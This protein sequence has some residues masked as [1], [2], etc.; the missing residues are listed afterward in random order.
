MA[1]STR[2][3]AAS[4]PSDSAS[5]SN[6][7]T[8][9]EISRVGIRVPPFWPE[10]PQLWFNQ[11]EAQFVLSG[12]TAD[13]TKFYYVMS[14]L[15]PKYAVQVQ[16]IF[17]NPPDTDKYETL[18]KELV[19]RLS[20][21]QGQ[22][23]RQLLEQ[24]EIGDRTPSQFLRH[25]RNLAGSTVTDDFLR[26]LWSGRLPAMTRAIVTAQADLSLNKL[27]EIADQ[28]HE[29]SSRNQVASV[30]SDRV[31]DM[32]LPVGKRNGTPLNAAISDGPR[33]SRLYVTDRVT[34]EEFLVD[35]GSDICVYP[36]TRIKGRISKTTHELLA[37]NSSTISTHG[38]KTFHLNLGL[39]R[40]F[41]WKFVIA[42]V[43]KP[44]IGA[45]FL[46]HYGLLVDLQKRRLLDQTT[47]L[48][49]IG[50]VITDDTQSVKT[51]TGDSPYH[52]LLAEFP[53]ITRPSTSECKVKHDVVHHIRT[54][55][56]PP[57]FCKPRRLSTEMFSLARAELE[58]LMRL[59][60]IRPSRSQWAS[61]LHM[62]QKKD[63]GWRPCG[64]YR[65]LNARTIP[66]R[67]PI[68]H[69]EDFSRMLFG[70]AVFSTIDLVRAYHQIPVHP[71][72]IPKTAITTPFGL[73]EYTAMSF[74]LR[75]AAQT[76]QCFIDTVLRGLDFCYAYLDDILVA[77]KD[78]A[79]HKDHLRQ[80][81]ARLEQYGIVVNSAK[82]VFAETEVNF[83]GYRVDEHGTKPLPDKKPEKST[84]RQF[85]YLDFI[86][87]FTT[88]IRHISGKDHEAADAL[89]R[90][91]S[92]A[93]AIRY[94]DLAESQA[95]DDELRTLLTASG[96]S[97]ILK[98]IK[99]DD[100][101]VYCDIS[102]D[103]VRPYTVTPRNQNDCQTSQ[104]AIRVA[105]H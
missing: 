93:T 99:H 96:T 47:S 83:L 51:I 63:K 42:D 22:R 9:Q 66:D 50:R 95:G 28:I 17:D 24:E 54:T 69:I 45:D 90:I 21:S 13:N 52:R 2:K 97:L 25:M 6:T 43:M 85:R 29:G 11:I 16:D 7:A 32:L 30:T 80:L 98:R 33:T 19:Q 64:D 103:R 74:G 5:A 20:M 40:A 73:F 48:T 49:A 65:A 78:E 12:V 84:P 58:N 61:A 46:S 39:R 27:A 105:V 68:P 15:E 104:R 76:F 4:A 67:Y 23:I 101:D 86:G 37:A 44:I 38:E 34:K 94:K 41:P 87:Q 53:N 100:T 10:Q 72:D 59:G 8:F 77:S 3:T 26:T 89:S 14:Q 60:H 56:G 36:R 82:C 102:T 79:E 62:V 81:F 88:D 1:M 57:I 35:T 91:E 75:N 55:A 18:K 92:I 70:K 71:S 31:V